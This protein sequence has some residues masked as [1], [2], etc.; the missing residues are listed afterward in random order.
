MTLVL[1]V[2]EE[3]GEHD[4]GFDLLLPQHVPEL[5]DCAAT[6][7]LRRDEAVFVVKSVDPIGVDVIIEGV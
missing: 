2:F 5:V 4:D 7:A 6:R 1:A 3:I